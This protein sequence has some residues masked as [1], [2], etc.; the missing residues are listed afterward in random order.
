VTGRGRRSAAALCVVLAA[1]TA[2]LACAASAPAA[3]PPP[4]IS[5]TIDD[6]VSASDSGAALPPVVFGTGEQVGADDSALIRLALALA[7]AEGV[8]V[9]DSPS[10][11][12]GILLQNG[13]PIS[14]TDAVRLL[15]GIRLEDGEAVSGADA[16]SLLLGLRLADGETVTT[17]DVASLLLA[18][19]QATG[20]SVSVGDDVSATPV[21][22]ATTTTVTTSASPAL[23]GS[24]VTF[25]ATVASGGHAVQAGSVAFSVD[26]TPVGQPVPVDGVGVAQLTTSSLGL[27]SHTVQA[28]YGGTAALLASSG[29][30]QQ[31]VWDYTLSL[32]PPSATVQRGGT[33]TFTVAAALVQGSVTTG[34][35]TL[36]LSTSTGLVGL[37]LAVPGTVAFDVPTDAS[38]PLGDRVITVTPVPVDQHSASA[39]LY[40]NAPPV[41]AAGGPYAAAEGAPVALHG[42]ATDPDGDTLTYTWNV[43]GVTASGA[44]ATVTAPDGPATVPVTLTVCDDHGACSTA[45]T[46][47]TVTNVPPAVTLTAAPSPASEGGT[48][49][50]TAHVTDPSAADTAAGFAIAFD[51]GSGTFTPAAGPSTTCPAVD[52][53]GVTARVRVT[54]K[55]GGS[56]IATLAVPIVNVAP[57]VKITAPAPGAVVFVGSHVPLGASFTDAGV[58]DTHTASFT[59]G[60]ATLTGAVT[61]SGGSGT[62]SAT[63]TPAASGVDTLTARVTDNAGATGSA[64]QALIVADQSGFVSG[65]GAIGPR[66]ERLIFTLEARYPR[67]SALPS[68]VVAVAGRGVV[69]HA[70]SFAW[71]VV[72]GRTA[73]LQGTGVANGAGGYSFTVQAVDGFPNRFAI[74]IWK[75]ATGAVLLDTGAP[76]A[77]EIGNVTVRS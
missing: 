19:R 60:G 48:F 77:L 2:L 71:L 21:V 74:K 17:S 44:D 34:L 9:I 41:A 15:L 76:A 47:L 50:L 38:T 37:Q 73:T 18:I 52:N 3:S 24:A 56:T 65:A 61:E 40:V 58:H 53:P 10:V 36:S 69:F 57:A 4:P 35:P 27:G 63:W 30:V 16:V 46:T 5:I 8:A 33:A 22:S 66:H 20:E 68:G 11:L 32:S 59:A 23:A 42:S 13:E 54:D 72:S 39:H 64:S 31:G 25:T 70:T 43:G 26:G 1:A 45:A 55:D 51:C 7:H 67:G 6:G 62:A 29:S 28:S 12:L 75:T 14:S 49:T